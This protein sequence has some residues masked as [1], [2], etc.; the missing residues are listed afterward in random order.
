MSVVNIDKTAFLIFNWKSCL[1][2]IL[3]CKYIG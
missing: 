1:I 3:L 2:I